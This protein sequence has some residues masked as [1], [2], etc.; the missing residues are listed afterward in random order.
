MRGVELKEEEVK[1]KSVRRAERTAFRKD[2]TKTL[3]GVKHSAEKR[4]GK[5]RGWVSRRI[6]NQAGHQMQK[7]TAESKAITR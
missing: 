1:G 6:L 3:D 7:Q 5:K 2:G 4:S